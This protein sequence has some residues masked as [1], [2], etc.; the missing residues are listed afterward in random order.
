MEFSLYNSVVA[1][2]TSG[3]G[4]TADDVAGA[5]HVSTNSFIGTTETITTDNGSINGGGD[6]GLEAL[7]DNG[8][9]I[10]TR[11]AM[12][13]SALI[14]AGDDASVPGG[15]TEDAN[16]NARIQ[17]AAVDIGAT[18]FTAVA[19]TPSLI[20]TIAGDT[21]DAFDGETSLREAVAFANSNADASTIT[22]DANLTGMTLTLTGGELT[23]TEETTVDGDLN[24]DDA[25]D[26]T[27]SGNDASRIFFVDPGVTATLNSLTLTGGS[28][29]GK[30]GAIYSHFGSTLTIAD[31]TLNGSYAYGG[32]A[33][34][35]Y[36]AALTITDSLLTGNMAALDNGGAIHA[37]YG[38]ASITNTTIDGNTADS[39]GGGIFAYEAAVTIVNS[40]ITGNQA[41][42]NL[43]TS[44]YG[45]GLAGHNGMEFSLYNTVVAE[46][47]SGTGMTANDVGGT[48]DT[49]T[50]SFFGTTVTI[51]ND[52][53]SI[54][55]GGDPG[56]A[57]LADNG[58]TT[59]TR[60]AEAGSALIDAG[61]DASVPMGL[62]EDANG[63][64]R[65]VGAAVDIG[66]TESANP[67]PV[68]DLDG[69]GGDADFEAAYTEDVSSPVAIADVDATITDA[70]DTD[71]DSLT[72]TI[73]DF[74]AGDVLAATPSGGIL[75]GDIVYDGLGTLT[76][77][78]A[79]NQSL[80]DFEA[81]L[82]SV[83]FSTT[84]DAPGTSRTINVVA[85][86]TGGDSNTAVSTIAITPTNDAPVVANLDG[87]T[88]TFV[89]ATPDPVA[90]DAGGDATAIEPDG[91][92]FNGGSLTVSL[93][94]TAL[95]E[96]TLLI[97]APTE[98]GGMGGGFG[99]GTNAPAMDTITIN[100]GTVFASG[101]AFGAYATTGAGSGLNGE[102]LVITFTTATATN[103]NVA[104]LLREIAYQ[105]AAER[106]MDPTS[107]TATVTLSDGAADSNVSTV[108]IDITPINRMV[109]GTPDPDSLEGGAGDDVVNG[110]GQADTLFGYFGD[111]TLNGGDGDD[112]LE[113]GPGSDLLNG[114]DGSD[115]ASYASTTVGVDV[116]I[117]SS[118]TGNGAAG[119]VISSIENV[120]GGSANDY[121]VGDV[122][123][124]VL[125]GG[126]G[127]D[128]L[129]GGG[130][131]DTL[132]GGA[133][134]D[135]LDGGNGSDTAS[136]A[137]S[138][139]GVNV[140]L[141]GGGIAANNDAAGDVLSNIE[142]LAGSSANDYLA[143]DG[144]DNVLTGNAGNDQLRG[145]TGDDTLIGGAGADILDGGSGSDTASYASATTGVNVRLY[146][147]GI[148]SNGDAAGD[149]L[150]NLENL[151]G[152]SANDYLAGDGL[153]NVLTGNDGNDQLRGGTGDDILVGGSGADVL[154]GGSGTD[155]ASYATD[156]AGVDVRLFDLSASGGEAAGDTISGI[157]NVIGGAGNDYLVGDIFANALTGGDGNDQLR[158][159]TG[160]DE[161]R[162]EA[163]DDVLFGHSGFDRIFGGDGD[164]LIEG[165]SS[166][167]AMDGGAG[168]DTLNYSASSAGV[169]V[170]LGAGTASGGDAAGDGF[171][172]FE[173]LF[174]SA[175]ADV[176]TGDGG[177]NFL[178]G[179]DGAD[180][181][182]GGGGDDRLDGGLGAD[183][184][185]GGAGADGFR[186]SG[187]LGTVDDVT[188]FSIADGDF[189]LLRDNVFTN[190]ATAAAPGG[191]ALGA[192]E[193]T[194]GA[195]AT[196]AD[197]RIVYDDTTGALSYDAD[198][199][200]VGAAVQFATLATGLALTSDD[201][202]VI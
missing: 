137:D 94:A 128:Q 151:T 201:V 134:A 48:V 25:A 142:N 50:N 60:N 114:G 88:A 22:F 105:N 150:S 171:A 28:A 64:A 160:D 1:E 149:V 176:L 146:G 131:A 52:T 68:V 153:D 158:G 42:V 177:A 130:S 144:Q 116:R 184:L 202:L 110:L 62:T 71:A 56:L 39:L 169:T 197:H 80:A 36:G 78:P 127:D 138:T 6:P 49:S 162:G 21:V 10:Q 123:S 32:G 96:D 129:R 119:D 188:D 82:R 85:N 70:V 178:R 107:R 187:A 124:N 145:G 194:I 163:A 8:G 51:T 61:D 193:F 122:F 44:V 59:Q 157:E 43:G 93:G 11:N 2:N 126:A 200:G 58:G 76:I 180:V 31:T 196:T 152:G 9:T 104:A 33:I 140:R 141:Y 148:A 66:A 155:T 72:V 65:I 5:I 35:G 27:I 108:T 13:G 30:G 120:T 185:T 7:A 55:G 18:E 15:L 81:V 159:G 112:V 121:I 109:D 90:L 198:G 133:G 115:T 83:V 37:R 111:D 23:L 67:P 167:D 125:K 84:S 136:Y 91:A 170:S 103:T 181:L 46:N 79:A 100:N 154:V 182:S 161:L 41:A 99:A 175:N 101:Q 47:T 40:T 12:S 191:A 183:T 75:A 20:V 173:N 16:G 57:A 24:A 98:A 19:E 192:A 117:F 156:T 186:F 26:V 34:Y 139:A 38:T 95:A 69:P 77:D 4:M 54:N 199:S 102:D 143:G 89:E 92:G 179:R 29:S 190:L 53:N 86:N 172:N 45:G 118:T 135:I 147:G 164:D 195:A 87:D 17:G 74:L 189:F 3:M 168:T 174:G 132:E 165:G 14:D 63:N 106:T 73:A 166:G 97:D 113:G